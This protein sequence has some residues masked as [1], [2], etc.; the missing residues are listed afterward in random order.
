VEAIICNPIFVKGGVKG[1]RVTIEGLEAN[2]IVKSIY[3]QN[4]T[5]NLAVFRSSHHG[6][7]SFQLLGYAVDD[8]LDTFFAC[9][10]QS[11]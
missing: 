11:I 10:A 8:P 6:H 7:D 5:M 3:D 2:I 9:S 1:Q 4:I